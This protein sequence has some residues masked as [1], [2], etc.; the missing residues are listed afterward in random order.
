MYDPQHRRID[1]REAFPTEATNQVSRALRETEHAPPVDKWCGTDA[2]ANDF[3]AKIRHCES[4]KQAC[5]R[6]SRAEWQHDSSGKRQIIVLDLRGELESRIYVTEYSRRD[7]SPKG[8]EPRAAPHAQKSCTN[9]RDNRRCADARPLDLAP[10]ARR[11]FVRN[12][13]H[14]VS[15]PQRD[16]ARAEPARM[17]GGG[18]YV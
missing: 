13:I 7:A 4:E 3:D 15:P 5:R 18:Q 16:R 6:T 12:R 8:N 11:H 10:D 9:H 1:L 14:V 17:H 2:S